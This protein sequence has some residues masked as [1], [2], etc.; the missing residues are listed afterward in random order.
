M[1]GAALCRAGAFFADLGFIPAG[2][3]R[4]PAYSHHVH[5]CLNRAW[6]EC[7]RRLARSRMRELASRR[8]HSRRAQ[9]DNFEI[10]LNAPT[11]LG[12][13]FSLRWQMHTIHG[14]ITLINGV[15]GDFKTPKDRRRFEDLVAR[16]FQ[17]DIHCGHVPSKP[18]V[19][20]DGQARR[21]TFPGRG[22]GK[23]KTTDKHRHRINMLMRC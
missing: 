2:T 19:L 5:A 10:V 3:A 9:V 20:Q 4:A 12:I 6:R 22:R 23:K 11:Y 15:C 14:H 17:M 7:L 18:L 1:E 8:K 16:L 13:K 21:S